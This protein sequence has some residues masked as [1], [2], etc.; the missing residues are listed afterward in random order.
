M[1]REVIADL[2]SLGFLPKAAERHEVQIGTFADLAKLALEPLALEQ[3]EA[4]VLDVDSDAPALIEAPKEPV[5]AQ[6]A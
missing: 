4:A 6:E 5:E 3:N 1:Q 2:Q